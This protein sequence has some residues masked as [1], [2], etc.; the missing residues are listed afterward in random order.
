[1]TLVSTFAELK[2]HSFVDVGFWWFL[3][4]LSIVGLAYLFQT[5][6]VYGKGSSG[7]LPAWSWVVFFPWHVLTRAVW[8]LDRSRESQP[9]WQWVHEGLAVGRRPLAGEVPSDFDHYVDLTAEFSEVRY[10]R[11]LPGFICFPILDGTA[12]KPESLLEAV[13]SVRAGK[14]FVH[15]AKGHGRTGLF[16]IAILLESGRVTSPEEGLKCLQT[17]RPGVR[18]NRAQWNCLAQFS[19]L[20][21]SGRPPQAG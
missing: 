6:R 20:I 4:D 8:Y 10:Y 21:D 3:V 2:P 19:N 9:G 17:V 7:R 1:M 12:P 16:A 11:Q 5:R 13:C 14:T 18:L 15:C